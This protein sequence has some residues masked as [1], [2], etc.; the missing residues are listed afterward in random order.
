MAVNGS[1]ECHFD[2]WMLR[3]LLDR[4]EFHRGPGRE[5]SAI[6]GV[7]CGRIHSVYYW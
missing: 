5:K 3:S 2:M 6:T 7:G 1:L 4:G